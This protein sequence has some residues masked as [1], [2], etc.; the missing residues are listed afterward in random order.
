M[1]HTEDHPFE[2]DDL[3]EKSR[4]Q[5]KREMEELQSLGENIVEL[6]DKYISRIPLEGQLSEAIHQARGMKH[7]EG[8]RRQLQFIGKLMRNAENIEAIRVAYEKILTIGRES[9]KTHHLAEQW[10]DKLVTETNKHL[11][12]FIEHY[13]NTDIQLLRQLIRNAQKEASQQ[14]PPAA[15]RKVYRLIRDQIEAKLAE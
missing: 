15:A 12:A 7:R 2:D 3:P 4:T 14:K 13:P 5:I 11:S 8:R 9:N 1:S 10:R 6:S